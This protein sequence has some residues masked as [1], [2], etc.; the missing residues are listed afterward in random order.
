MAAKNK[1]YVDS[2]S[3][4]VLEF[5]RDTGDII[6]AQS[7]SFDDNNNNMPAGGKRKCMDALLEQTITTL[8][9]IKKNFKEAEDRR[10]AVPDKNLLLQVIWKG[11]DISILTAR[12]FDE[13]FSEIGSRRRHPDVDVPRYRVESV[14]MQDNF[15]LDC[16]KNLQPT[17]MC[18]V[19]F[20]THEDASTALRLKTMSINVKQDTRTT[21]VHV[22]FIQPTQSSDTHE[23]FR[24]IG[25]SLARLDEID[26]ELKKIGAERHGSSVMPTL[27]REFVDKVFY[28]AEIEKFKA[29]SGKSLD[30]QAHAL[31]YNRQPVDLVHVNTLIKQ[32]YD[33]ECNILVQLR[34]FQLKGVDFNF[35]LA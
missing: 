23:T 8:K 5:T 1:E 22:E 13:K 15:T 7:S 33:E 10:Q 28:A 21:T 3:Q 18:F 25:N 19:K 9:N 11:H 14:T 35:K 6:K 2:T 20:S 17:R 27:K 24:I 29:S 34:E 31:L 16:N 4:D 26:K 30:Q 32:L 12:D